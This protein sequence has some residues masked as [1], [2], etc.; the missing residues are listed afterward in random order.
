MSL[1]LVISDIRTLLELLYA[2]YYAL[3]HIK[4]KLLLEE[5]VVLLNTLIKGHSQ[6]IIL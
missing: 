1:E 3:L 4:V 2:I 6:L 5:N